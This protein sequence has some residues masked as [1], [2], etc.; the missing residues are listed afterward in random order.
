MFYQTSI[1]RR[2]KPMFKTVDEDRETTIK[3]D[4]YVESKNEEYP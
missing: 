3:H 4:R 1:S 2:S